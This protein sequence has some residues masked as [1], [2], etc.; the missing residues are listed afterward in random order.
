MMFFVRGTAQTQGSIACVGHD[1]KGRAILTSDNARLKAWRLTV[2]AGIRN[3]PFPRF[4]SGPATVRVLFVLPRKKTMPKKRKLDA[5][6]ATGS[7][8]DK[9]MR[10]ILDS[11]SDRKCRKTG[12]TL[13]GKLRNDRQVCG[14]IVEKRYADIGE[15]PGAHIEIAPYV[16]M[17][18]AAVFESDLPA[19][20]PVIKRRVC[21][22]RHKHLQPRG[23]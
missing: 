17:I 3:A 19:P 18:E 23:L 8:L 9:L 1:R 10:A 16:P 14:G 5:S 4:D 13:E 20:A 6:Q 7:D 12:R 15:A 11:I 22:G 21:A 2:E